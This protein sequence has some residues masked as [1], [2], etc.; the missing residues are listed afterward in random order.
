MFQRDGWASAPNYIYYSAH[1]KTWI[2]KDSSE[3]HRE[4]NN[5]RL[6]ADDREQ[7]YLFWIEFCM[8][9]DHCVKSLKEALFAIIIGAATH[10]TYVLSHFQTQF[11]SGGS[12][13]RHAAITRHAP[14]DEWLLRFGRKDNKK[15]ILFHD[16]F[17]TI[18]AR[19]QWYSFLQAQ[20][21]KVYLGS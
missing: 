13:F 3:G 20:S 19:Y 21:E 16:S 4:L 15:T 12:K 7:K 14:L 5:L 9:L 2:W 11:P 1:E 18:H 6:D 17:Y 10:R 8:C